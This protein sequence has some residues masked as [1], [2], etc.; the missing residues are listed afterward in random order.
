MTDYIFG[1]W[2]RGG[3]EKGGFQ[4]NFH[5]LR[6]Q[7]RE[8]LAIVNLRLTRQGIFPSNKALIL[9]QLGA[10]WKSVTHIPPKSEGGGEGGWE[11][12]ACALSS[13]RLLLSHQIYYPDYVV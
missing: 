2:G 9:R 3:K 1:S 7:S 6:I 4:K 10:S 8:D 12:S 11:M 13:A 5:M